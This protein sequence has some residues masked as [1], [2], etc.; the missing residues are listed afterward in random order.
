M[1]FR[2][3]LM[4]LLLL[5]NFRLRGLLAAVSP[6]PSRPLSRAVIQ[7]A[8][9]RRPSRAPAPTPNVSGLIRSESY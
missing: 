1:K 8:P 4:T 5:L 2:D 3:A 9:S 7:D 6:S